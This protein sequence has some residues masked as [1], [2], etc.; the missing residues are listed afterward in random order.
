VPLKV[1]ELVVERI[2]PLNLKLASPF[3]VFAVPVAVTK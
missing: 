1:I 3:N 2:V